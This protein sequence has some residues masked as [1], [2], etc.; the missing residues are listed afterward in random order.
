MLTEK[1]GFISAKTFL[2][3]IWF[4]LSTKYINAVKNRLIRIQNKG[5]V[6][7]IYVVCAVVYL[8]CIYKYK[9]THAGIYLRKIYY[10]IY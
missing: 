6:Y 4:N 2:I 3:L 7:I 1:K 9:H 8:L 5:F 10:I